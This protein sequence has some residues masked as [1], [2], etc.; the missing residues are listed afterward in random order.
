MI[1]GC[2]IGLRVVDIY[3]RAQRSLLWLLQ[4]A[5]HADDG[6]VGHDTRLYACFLEN[7]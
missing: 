5:I 3:T 6:G 1:H 2:R 4:L 7:K